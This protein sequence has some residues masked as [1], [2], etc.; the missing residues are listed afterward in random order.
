MDLSR[1]RSKWSRGHTIWLSSSGRHNIPACLVL[2]PLE[3]LFP[4]IQ[5]KQPELSLLPGL[6]W[7]MLSMIKKCNRSVGS[8]ITMSHY[9]IDGTCLLRPG[10]SGWREEGWGGQGMGHPHWS[11]W[12][13]P[14]SLTSWKQGAPHT[15]PQLSRPEPQ[16]QQVS[17]GR[18]RSPHSLSSEPAGSWRNEQFG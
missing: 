2:F 13:R 12:E 18:P 9:F 16:A 14:L 8:D 17:R 3:D 4:N 1:R 15:G 7:I 5:R 11:Q 10:D 6:L